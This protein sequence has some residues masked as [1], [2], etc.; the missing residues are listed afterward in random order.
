M[1]VGIISRSL[2][3]VIRLRTAWPGVTRLGVSAVIVAW[4]RI[5]IA[6]RR[7][8]GVAV[9]IITRW[10]SVSVFR[11]CIFLARTWTVVFRRSIRLGISATVNIFPV[12]AI[13]I[14]IVAGRR[15]ILI[16]TL[17]LNITVISRALG[18]IAWALGCCTRAIARVISGSGSGI[19]YTCIRDSRSG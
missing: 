11:R 9:L 2:V 4:R 5:T 14:S 19:L 1:G 15:S 3:A 17:W 18:C 6:G 12:I 7:Y 13:C 10:L 8:S 16:M